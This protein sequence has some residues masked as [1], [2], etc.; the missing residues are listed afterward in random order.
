MS[1]FRFSRSIDEFHARASAARGLDDFG[2]D[3]Y[4]PALDV[5]CA[6]LDEDARLSPLGELG[7]QAMIVEALEARLL[8]EEGFRRHPETAE[9][10]IERPVFI[11]GLPRTG[12]TALHH[13]MAQAPDVQALEHWLMRTPRPRPPRAAWDA[14]PDY[15]AALARVDL[16]FARSPEMRAI[17]EIEAFLPDECW[18]LFSQNFVHSSYEANADVRGYA[19]WWASADLRPVYARHRRNAR[20]IGSASPDRRWLF[21]DATHLFGLDALLE[22]YPD[23]RVIQTHRD[24]APLIASVCSLCWASRTAMN[25]HTD[26]DAFGRSTLALWQRSIDA[27]MAARA[28]ADPGRFYDLPF[29][30]FVSDPLAALREIY[31]WLEVDYTPA[32]DAAIR[33]FRE[34]HPKGQHGA[35]RYSLSE[36][37]LTED[38]VREHFTRY[39]D[40]FGD[41][42]AR[43]A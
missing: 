4:R 20:L 11:I 25:E 18:N 16:M 12:T 7:F 24:P 40:A 36:Y 13:L 30:R 22:I 6:S 28:Q 15:Q 5:L 32:A 26:I 14:D 10:P 43:P 38:E 29:H 19:A 42:G 34:A 17:H 31:A 2:D 9:T 41:V 23:A 39:S 8:C 3:D 33:G 35:H 21:K 37:G 1:P 27:M